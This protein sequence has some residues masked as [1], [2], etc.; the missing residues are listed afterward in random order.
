[1]MR[2]STMSESNTRPTRRQALSGIA[3]A[4]AFAAVPLAVSANATTREIDPRLLADP[5]HPAFDRVIVVGIDLED[6]LLG[7]LHVEDELPENA[8]TIEADHLLRSVHYVRSAIL[9][10]RRTGDEGDMVDR[11]EAAFKRQ[12]ANRQAEHVAR[13]AQRTR[14]QAEASFYPD[15]EDD[16]P[17]DSV[18]ASV[19]VT[20]GNHPATIRLMLALLAFEEAC[21]DFLWVREE[22][23]SEA[24]SCAEDIDHLLYDVCDFREFVGQDIVLEGD[25]PTAKRELAMCQKMI[26]RMDE[27]ASQGYEID[28]MQTEGALYAE[29]DKRA[30]ELVNHIA[31][32]RVRDGNGS[33]EDYDRMGKMFKRREVTR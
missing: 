20:E 3:A 12:L 28:A 31:I 9:V 15:V 5:N 4:A 24:Q 32:A 25:C 10:G 19:P 26:R 13:P 27:L 16:S 1:M 2:E 18:R 8:W 23:G 29:A 14:Y 33:K 21:L 7:L 6:A 22:T 30:D 17:S 11:R